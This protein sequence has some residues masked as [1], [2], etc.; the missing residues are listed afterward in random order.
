MNKEK[1]VKKRDV[2]GK[3]D[4]TTKEK[5]HVDN[6]R[7]GEAVSSSTTDGFMV[8]NGEVIVIDG[9]VIGNHFYKELYN[10]EIAQYL[11]GGD[12]TSLAA[13]ERREEGI[14][15][16]VKE[17]MQG[18][19]V[20]LSLSLLSDCY[21]YVIN[22]FLNDENAFKKDYFGKDTAYTVKQ[23]IYKNMFSAVQSYKTTL[24]KKQDAY[25]NSTRT[26][27]AEE[28][29]RGRKGIP[30]S[31]IKDTTLPEEHLFEQLDKV[32]EQY[33]FVR[34]YIE[35]VLKEQ[36]YIVENM[37]VDNII[38]Y[39][40][41]VYYET[42]EE[43]IETI[44]KYCYVDEAFIDKFLKELRKRITSNDK[45]DRKFRKNLAE[46]IDMNKY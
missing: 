43:K 32:G 11:F 21:E 28:M 23:Y 19:K 9:E 15:N 1:T 22:Y 14:I 45:E 33:R 5:K 44:K 35:N 17:V 42:D 41:I 10:L 37:D 8:V 46:L 40:F 29:E 34:N 6:V 16:R 27:T 4:I 26:V 7:S 25:Y 13:V 2:K 39:F 18:E 38:R 31:Y 3:V 12:L 30:E 24:N 20:Q 36:N